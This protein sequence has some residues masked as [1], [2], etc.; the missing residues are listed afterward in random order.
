M[1]I[2]PGILL[3]ILL[4]TALVAVLCSGFD[5]RMR[6]V[7][8]IRAIH[9]K[10]MLKDKPRNPDLL[11]RKVDVLPKKIEEPTP[12][13]PMIPSKPSAVSE[14]PKIPKL[15]DKTTLSA[16][17]AEPKATPKT[18]PK[19]NTSYAQEL[20]RLSESFAAELAVNSKD[21]VADTDD[22]GNYFDQIYLLVKK[23]F[24][25]PA[26]IN[27][28]QGQNLQAVL[29]LFLSP[30]GNLSRLNLEQSSGDEHFDKAVMDGTKRV[31]NFGAVPL[32]LQ[33]TL[34]ENGVLVEMCPFKCREQHG[35]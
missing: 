25:V 10:L 1:Q 12:T 3:S 29:R 27:G 5:F 13:P 15:E 23:S 24:V 9:A 34:S 6:P 2:V 31:N 20:A 26:H 8:N 33:R 21:S 4:H 32:V 18:K 22:D 14:A 17:K 19:A 28:P 16:K 35:G 7:K 30:D 11:P